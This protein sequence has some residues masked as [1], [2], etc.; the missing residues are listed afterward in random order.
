MTNL[1]VKFCGVKFKNPTVLASGILGVTASSLKNVVRC[2][3]G[4]VTTKSIW[5]NENAGHKNPTMFGTE[6]Y[7]L[8]AV[9]LSDAGIEKAVSET[10]PE[11]LKKKP[12]PIIASIVAANIDDFGRLAEEITKCKPDIIEV[13][14]ACPNVEDKHGKPFS[15]VAGDS[16]KVTK[17]VRARTKK[18]IIIKLTP[19][20][21]NI[22]EI[23]SA[24]ADS[25]ADGFCAINT[26]YG[27]EIDINVRMPILA[28]KSGGVSGPGIKPVAVKA[29]Y[30][31]YKATKLPII[32]TGGIMT[33]ED[34]IG[35]MMAG[36]RLVG[37]GTMVYY[38]G[39]EGFGEV[40]SEMENW[41]AKNG[42]KNI[43]EIIGCA[44]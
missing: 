38:R 25:G 8:N 5:L 7:F 41:C 1:L 32:G 36:A 39:A 40:V 10:F 17:I 9:G 26:L 21:Y 24:C 13:N 20:V 22:G 23:A 42:V 43:E 18:P 44:H 11:Y 29:V 3:A 6:H 28:N 34:A 35:M 12:A 16:A 27:M 4:G 15:C 37:I 33:G 19:N 31:I 30:D 2:G 14:I